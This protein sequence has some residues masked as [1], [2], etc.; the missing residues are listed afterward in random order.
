MNY[1]VWPRFFKINCQT[2]ICQN[3]WM[4][5]QQHQARH[6]AWNDILLFRYSNTYD[7]WICIHYYSFKFN[8]LGASTFFHME[9]PNFSSARDF[10]KFGTVQY[11]MLLWMT[12]RLK[13]MSQAFKKNKYVTILLSRVKGSWV[14]RRMREW[15]W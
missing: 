11:F 9:N 3:I 4:W 13:I 2:R 12:L 14:T 6:K 5:W 15:L 1:D 10:V 8:L 7:N